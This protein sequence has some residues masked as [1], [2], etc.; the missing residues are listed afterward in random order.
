MALL[1]FVQARTR[2]L[3]D[4]IE[5]IRFFFRSNRR[6]RVV[7]AIWVANWPRSHFHT[8]SHRPIHTKK[9]IR[10]HTMARLADNVPVFP[11]ASGVPKVSYIGGRRVVKQQKKIWD[12]LP[13]T[14]SKSYRVPI[15]TS[16][17][18]TGLFLSLP[19]E[20]ITKKEETAN[21]K[22]WET[23]NGK[24]LA[25]LERA[26]TPWWIAMGG[27]RTVDGLFTQHMHE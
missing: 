7:C 8:L 10:L 11:Y 26:V 20:A 4:A 25:Q 16:S 13:E 19:E 9:K 2:V 18:E 14:R 3:S 23:V 12:E 22:E 17:R 5:W 24:L 1:R 27:R 6:Y 21:K 15:E